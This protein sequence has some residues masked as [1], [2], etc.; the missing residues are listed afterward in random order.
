MKKSTKDLLWIGAGIGVVLLYIKGKAVE[1]AAAVASPATPSATSA[2]NA[3]AAAAGASTSATEAAGTVPG[4]ST[5]SGSSLGPT[6][7]D[8]DT[9]P[10]TSPSQLSGYVRV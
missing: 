7:S 2:A 9:G 10:I 4:T 8:T 3:A 1:A 5:I 6:A